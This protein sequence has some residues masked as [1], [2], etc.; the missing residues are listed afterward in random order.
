MDRSWFAP[1]SRRQRIDVSSRS[2]RRRFVRCRR[3]P[4]AGQA[5]ASHSFAGSLTSGFITTLSFNAYAPV[6]SHGM[7]VWLDN[8]QIGTNPQ[9]IEIF[10]D[11]VINGWVMGVLNSS[12]A[13]YIPG[14][15]GAPISFEAVIDMSDQI[16]YAVYDFGSGPQTSAAL[17]LV[18][19]DW[20]QV[21]EVSISGD[22]RSGAPQ[23]EIDNIDLS[24]TSA[25][26]EPSTFLL[27]GLSCLVLLAIRIRARQSKKKRH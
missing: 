3:G 26:P 23:G 9:G 13:I 15:T 14:G 19:F 27:T 17:S 21:N 4:F 12:E 6:G 8:G 18:G 24:Q 25:I 1:G 20:S 10:T 11:A 16:V 5:V 7:V 22:C 2:C